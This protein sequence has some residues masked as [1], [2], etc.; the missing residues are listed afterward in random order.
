M[1]HRSWCKS[2]HVWFLV[3]HQLWTCRQILTCAFCPCAKMCKGGGGASNQSSGVGQHSIT[4]NAHAGEYKHQPKE[5]GQDIG[6]A[7]VA[8]AEGRWATAFDGTCDVGRAEG[9]TWTG[10]WRSARNHLHILAANTSA[11]NSSTSHPL[12]VLWVWE[13]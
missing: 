2:P 12:A 8:V 9:H 13:L 1:T 4:D 10:H 11:E 7:F 5:H 6:A 3:G